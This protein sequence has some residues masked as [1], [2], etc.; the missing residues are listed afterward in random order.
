[1]TASD[2]LKW[3]IRSSVKKNEGGTLINN[4]NKTWRKSLLFDMNGYCKLLTFAVKLVDPWWTSHIPRMRQVLTTKQLWMVWREPSMVMV[5]QQTTGDGTNNLKEH[6]IKLKP[7][8]KE[9][10]GRSPTGITQNIGWQWVWSDRNIN[11]H[12]SIELLLRTL[13]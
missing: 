13:S 7:V 4:H 8:C 5:K 12:T 2:E 10:S 6:L 3:Q 11:P 9:F 1:M